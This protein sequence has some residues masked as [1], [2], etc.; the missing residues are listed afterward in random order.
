MNGMISRV[1][2]TGIGGFCF[3]ARPPCLDESNPHFHQRA[4]HHVRSQ[5]RW[6]CMSIDVVKQYAQLRSKLVAEQTRLE[7]R[8]REVNRVLGGD[9]PATIKAPAVSKSQPGRAKKRLKNALSL[10]AAAVQATSAKPLTKLEILAAV[11]KLG[12]K[13]GTN[14]PMQSLNSILY[15]AN[16]KFKRKDGKFS[17]A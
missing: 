12:Y 1:A 7:A 8:L 9:I 17:P 16:P 4:S 14:K 13:F 2:L 6:W 3:H 15:G 10:R 11:Q 5:I